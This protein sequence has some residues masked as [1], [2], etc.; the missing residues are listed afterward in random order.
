MLLALIE[1]VDKACSPDYDGVA[2]QGWF[3]HAETL[4]PLFSLMRLPG[5]FALPLNWDNLADEWR[6]QEITP[7]GANLAI[8]ILR[9]VTGRHYAAVRLNGRTVAPIQGAPSLLPGNNLPT[10]GASRSGLPET[11]RN[12][13]VLLLIGSPFSGR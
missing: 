6:L 5:C 12:P 11:D 8:L 2:L 4:L 13:S 1:S 3:G 10:S 7:L 9:S